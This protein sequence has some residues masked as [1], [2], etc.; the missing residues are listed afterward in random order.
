MARRRDDYDDD[1]DDRRPRVPNDA[2][3]GLLGISLLALILATLFLYLDYSSF[4][5]QTPAGPS[6][7]VPALGQAKGSGT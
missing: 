4:P 1:D 7:N 6:V 5:E 2:Y 3:T